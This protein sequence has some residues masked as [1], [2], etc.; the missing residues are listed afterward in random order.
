MLVR[1][2]TNKQTI[3]SLIMI[4]KRTSL[5]AAILAVVGLGVS[6]QAAADIYAGSLLQITD[7]T[8]NI[9]GTEVPPTPL[10][11]FGFNLDNTATLN[12]V[13]DTTAGIS[14]NCNSLG[15]PACS[16]VS[17]VLS[18]VAA[19]APGSAPLRVDGAANNF[20]FFGPGSGLTYA[21][22]DSEIQTA[23]LIQ[24]V[25]TTTIQIS[26]AEIAGT[27]SGQSSTNVQSQT[28]FSFNFSI[29]GDNGQ[30][31]LDFNADPDLYVAV[32][33]LN[34]AASLAQANT[35]ATFTLSS[36]DATG[37][38][39]NISWS[40]NGEAGGITCTG[41]TCTE[42]NDGEDLNNSI[43]L[44]PGLNPGDNGISDN[45]FAGSP[46]L[47]FS[48]FGITITGLSSGNYSLTLAATSS[49]NVVQRVETPEPSTL[50][51]LGLSMAMLGF[52]GY[53]RKKA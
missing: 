20:S 4:T 51:L 14:S 27:G 10:V 45:R 33:T 18:A 19:N 30:L 41:A 38:P 42:D 8:I 53:R 25:P 7:L 39:V 15:V 52:V 22:S 49:V 16:V 26:E 37:G 17:P 2:E 32:D 6:G 31:V 34:L 44:P 29:S 1:L 48:D 46:D 43:G 23:E 47:G 21:N 13:S 36:T 3:R 40:P 35:G 5:A 11:D 24:G 12:G 28:T 50:G 9:T